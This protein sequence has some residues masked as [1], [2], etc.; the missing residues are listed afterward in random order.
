MNVFGKIA[1]GFVW[2]GKEIG[3]AV[4]WMPKII[5]LSDDIKTDAATLLP[6]LAQVV[7]DVSLLA[8]AAVKDSAADLASAERLIAAIG[9]AA[10]SEALDI[11]ADIRVVTALEDFIKTV[12]NSS[13]YADFIGAV[14]KLV[15]DYDKFGASAKLALHQLEKDAVS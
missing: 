2:I 14:K 6:E 11:A 10:K 13:N 1:S 9:V 7:E 3:R 5:K 8:K 12:T 4:N 15:V